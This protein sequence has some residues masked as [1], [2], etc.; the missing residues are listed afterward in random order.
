MRLNMNTIKIKSVLLIM[1]CLITSI[2]LYS[3]SFKN[4]T[5]QLTQP[6]KTIVD[7]FATG[8]DPGF[9]RCHDANDYTI[10]KD[11]KTGFFCWAYLDSDGYLESTGFPIHLYNPKDLG[12][13][14]GIYPKRL[15]DEDIKKGARDL[16]EERMKQENNK[17]E[18]K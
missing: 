4:L 2:E 1:I 10:V 5:V 8:N 3:T 11:R 15:R 9:I 14:P 6:D 13:E 7:A 16:Q 18:K 17:G 12:L